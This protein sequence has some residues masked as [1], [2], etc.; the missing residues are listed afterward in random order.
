M[1][2][3]EF[4]KD[5]QERLNTLKS[6][7]VLD[8]LAEERFDRV[9]RMAKRLFGTPI[10]LVSLVDEDRQWFKSC[11]GLDATETPRDVSFCGH[12]IL[13][14]RVFVVSN[15]KE[16][17]RFADN[18]LVTE[19]PNIG[20]YAGCPLT[21]DGRKMGT[22]C[23]IDQKPREFDDE[24]R[25]ALADLASIVERELGEVEKATLDELTD[26]PNRRGFL[27]HA[28]EILKYGARQNSLSTL[29]FFDLDK[30]KAINDEFGHLE[31]DRALVAFASQIKA[32]IRDSD[33]FARFG[34]DEFVA[35]LPNTSG[36]QAELLITRISGMLAK[37]SMS[38][39]RGYNVSFSYGL[40]EIN[41]GDN[42]GLETLLANGDELMYEAKNAKR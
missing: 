38:A 5:E 40:V 23:V 32:S 15:T 13:G 35:L 12:A 22:L 28:P 34:G 4:P 18:P 31:G 42:P 1:Q 21:V 3:P 16:D 36:K 37:Y 2:P 41:P 8:T 25:E 20:F 19:D 29:V 14:D 27:I 17:T 6:L 10:A 33:L 39:N 26:T 9:T 7:D 24:D 30:L 11:V